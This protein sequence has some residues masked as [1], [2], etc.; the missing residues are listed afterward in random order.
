[1]IIRATPH[2]GSSGT[3]SDEKYV[4]FTYTNEKLTILEYPVMIVQNGIWQTSSV[5]TGSQRMK[6]VRE[7]SRHADVAYECTITRTQDF[8]RIPVIGDIYVYEMTSANKILSSKYFKVCKGEDREKKWHF[9]KHDIVFAALPVALAVPVV[10]QTP[11]KIPQHIFRMFVDAAV[12]KKEEC[13]ITMEPLTREM[14]AGTSCGHLFDREAI[15]RVLRDSGR[16]PTCRCETDSENLQT[17]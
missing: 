9:E 6:V 3:L 17:Y 13:P 4:L 14:V 15:K 12:E 5:Q 10:S 11:S 2:R 16:C 1:M 7:S 8:V